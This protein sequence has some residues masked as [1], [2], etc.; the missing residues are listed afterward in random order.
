[1]VATPPVVAHIPPE[2]TG[3]ATVTLWAMVV[4]WQLEVTVWVPAAL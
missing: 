1:M 2:A 4:G 3:A